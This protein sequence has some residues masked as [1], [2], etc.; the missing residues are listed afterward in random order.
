MSSIRFIRTFVAVARY[1]SF[2]A[3]AE[4]ISLTQAAVSLQ[5]RALEDELRHPLFDRSGRT[6]RLNSTGVALLPRAE[7]LLAVYD[8]LR[9]FAGDIDEASGPMAIGA[10]VS[11]MGA[12][13][14]LIAQFKRTHPRLDIR[15]ITGK[16]TELVE[17]VEAGHIDTAIIVEPSGKALPTSLDWSPLFS[18]PLVLLSPA[19]SSG[20]VEDVLREQPFLR[21]D[22]SQ[23]TGVLID[24]TLRRAQLSTQDFLELN[25]IETIVELVRQEVGVAVLPL[26]RRASW[27]HDSALRVTPIEPVVPRVIGMLEHRSHPR[28]A[29]TAAIAQFLRDPPPTPGTAF[30][31]T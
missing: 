23:H 13:A 1:G 30:A 4:R 8:E 2:A 14:R 17:Q 25:S 10:V 18:E 20:N 24:R 19:R 7:K 27:H 6:V 11:V 12:L 29:V 22:R 21:F 9:S 26:L 16:S 5:M 3:A 28:A 15:L 31:L